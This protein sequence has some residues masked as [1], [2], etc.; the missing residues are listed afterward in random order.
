MEDSDF[1]SLSSAISHFV[2][3]LEVEALLPATRLSWF[4]RRRVFEVDNYVVW[5]LY[6]NVPLGFVPASSTFFLL[7][8]PEEVGVPVVR[9][10]RQQPGPLPLCQENELCRARCHRRRFVAASATSN[11]FDNRINEN[12]RVP[13]R[14][15]F[16]I[17]GTSFRGR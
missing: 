7:S 2:I 5:L 1:C 11:S 10:S 14:I 6:E 12:A 17:I 13:A 3:R 8:G 4:V 9:W 15:L 16:D